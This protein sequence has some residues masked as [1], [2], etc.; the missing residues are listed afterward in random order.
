[1]KALT[2]NNIVAR[3]LAG[4]ARLAIRFRWAVMFVS[5]VLFAGSILVTLKYPGLQFDTDRDNLVGANKSYH[6]NYLAF[7]KEFPQPE[8]LI[9]VV[10]S[11]DPEKNRQFVERLAA[12]V[13][14]QTNLF[15]DVFYK[16][17]LNMMGDKAL[18]FIPEKELVDFRDQLESYR[19]FIQKFTQASNLVSLV[20][21]VNT[22]F[23]TAKREQ[24][25]DN[26]SLINALPALERIIRQ[27]KNSLLHRG[28]PPSPGVNALFDPD[29]KA[30]QQIYITFDDGRIFLLTAHARAD[31]VNGDAVERLRKLV[32]ATKYEVP[33]VNAGLT[34]GPVLEHDEMQQS[35]KDMTVATV[36]ALVICALIFIYGYQ[37]TGRPI[38]ATACL[39]VG[40]GYTMAFATLA[41]GHLNILTVTFLPMLVGLAID[42]GVHLIT[43]YEEELH[44]G[45][46][47]EDALIKAMVFTGQGIFTGAF[48][49]AGAFFAMGLTDF[50]GIKEMGIICGGGLMVCLIP[51][52]TLLPVLLLRGRQNVLD[53]DHVTQLKPEKRARIERI[54]LDRPVTVSIVTLGLCGLAATQIPKLFFDYDLLNLQS[55]GLSSVEYDKK[56]IALGTN[57]APDITISS[58]S[59]QQTNTQTRTTIYGVVMAE[60]PED[61]L[62]VEQK[63][64]QLPAVANVE[65]IA[66][67]LTGDQTK[68][69]QIIGQIKD[70]MQSV[71]FADLDLSSVDVPELSRTL[72]S[73]YG[74]LGLALD[75]VPKAET[76]LRSKLSSLRDAV[77]ELRVEMLR[78]SNLELDLKQ[79]KLTKFQENL[80]EDLRDTFQALKHQD[81]SAPLRVQDLPK[82][83]KDRFVGVTGKI[84]LQVYPRKNI[85]KRENQEEFVKQLWSVDPKATGEPVELYEYVSLLKNSYEQAA[86]YSLAA[87]ALL[88]FIHFRT[89]GS[90]VLSLLP[91]AVGSLWLCGIMG[92]FHIPF[93]PANIMTLPLVIGIGVTNGIHILNRFAEEH[94]PSILAKSTGK[95]VLVSGLTTIAGF[96]S[97][98]LAKHQG[99]KSLGIIM[100]IGVAGCMIAGLTFL[101]AL[102]NIWTRFRNKQQPSADKTPSA[103]GWEEPR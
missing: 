34:G 93:N 8:D 54:W 30:D 72:Y 100:A 27:A 85:W 28:T 35:Q 2:D 63:L 90:V 59:D 79:K 38:K 46:S 53:H 74:Y 65:S 4:I 24:N 6:R 56:L 36:V 26:D 102:L 45:R 58:D 73:L 48:T 84:L 29:G 95:A 15:T 11:D 52:L 49:T 103:P 71:H 43:R 78:G 87:I 62:K 64:D 98:I 67:Y 57:T 42:F 5:F 76:E 94:T 99:I 66:K 92:F 20:E 55:K 96:G 18:L 40:L 16:G 61:A 23:R 88:V 12:K 77:S 17:S 25:A 19:P 44:H 37:Q 50:K 81:N 69:L 51:M 41:I 31:E 97:L 91:V 33:G 10:E 70:M 83:L 1:M 14:P 13:Q 32:N 60:S 22:Q 101:P 68:Q 39:I 75:N 7:R 89:P 82:A 86:L 3:T 80:F 9:V 47:E 21:M